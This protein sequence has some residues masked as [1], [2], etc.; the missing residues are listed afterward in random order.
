M[1]ALHIAAFAGSAGAAAQTASPAASASPIVVELFTSQG[2]SSCPPSDQ[3][4]GELAKR[5]DLLPLSLH[6]DY[7]D[8]IGWKDPFASPVNTERQRGYARA[9]KQRYIYTPE[10]VVGGLAH[11]PGYDQ[12]KIGKMLRM[13]TER[14]GPRALPT[15]ARATGNGITI[16]IPETRLTVAC[17]VWLVT[18]DRQRRTEVARG[19]NKGVTL[20]NHNVVRSFEKLGTWN[21]DAARWTVPAER[22]GP[23]QSLAVVVQQASFGPIIGATRLD[24]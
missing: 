2:C 23:G 21:G 4:L 18:F 22:V 9:L 6:V 11:D 19:E 10:M 3:Q 14:S 1:V 20:V 15:M 16:T 24:R 12:A 5:S 7:W 17:D 8:Y 13:A